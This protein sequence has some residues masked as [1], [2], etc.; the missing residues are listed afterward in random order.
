MR[1]RLCGSSNLFLYFTQGNR[2]EY[3][4]FKCSTCGLVNYDLSGGL[5][6]EKYG[7]VFPDPMDNRLKTNRSQ[8]LTW[9]FIEK[10]IPRKGSLIDIGCG[11]GRLL[12]SART[13]GW[14]VHGLEL[15]PMLAEAIRTR[16]GIEV[17]AV[18]FLDSGESSA[19]QFDVAVMRHVLEH[20]PDPVA[21][22]RK[23]GG[24]LKPNGYAVLEFP[25]IEAWDLKVRRR[26]RSLGLHRKKYRPDYRPGHCN[27]FSRTSFR[28]LAE[29]A[30]FEVR[31]WETY[32]LPML[33]NLFLHLVPVGGKARALVQKK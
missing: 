33:A 4:F 16:F 29:T 14:Q 5:D 9:K 27:E 28:L 23:I 15:S 25:N 24:L 26:M 19:G 12:L 6:Q 13:N 30:G 8:E 2:G 17:E 20:L 22:M 3:K 31:I 21:A 18:N 11:N 10:H 7:T 1:C 32:S